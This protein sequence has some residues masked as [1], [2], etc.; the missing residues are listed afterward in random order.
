M[1]IIHISIADI[2]EI[3]CPTILLW[4]RVVD[5]IIFVFTIYL[6]ILNL[7]GEFAIENK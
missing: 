2:N 5:K 1:V 4:N 3:S 6:F 7:P